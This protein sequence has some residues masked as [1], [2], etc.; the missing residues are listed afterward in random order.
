MLTSDEILEK[1]HG[2]MDEIRKFG[3]K[4][5]GLFGSYVKDEQKIGSDI[6]ILVEFEKDQKTFDHYMDLKFFL[7]ELF[8]LKVDLV[9]S[10]ALKPDLKTYIL[11]S[12]KYASGI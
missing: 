10:E 7:E 5:I 9:I 8:E 12:V 3:V 2:N 11:D 4:K 6:D 1:I